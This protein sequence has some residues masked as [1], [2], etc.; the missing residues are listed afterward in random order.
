MGTTGD[1]QPSS[2]GM[3]R[4]ACALTETG[5]STADTK[6][7][8]KTLFAQPEITRRNIVS[9]LLDDERVGTVAS[10]HG[11]ERAALLGVLTS[12]K[13]PVGANLKRA[14]GTMRQ[15]APNFPGGAAFPPNLERTTDAAMEL[16]GLYANPLTTIAMIFKQP[17]PPFEAAAKMIVSDVPLTHYASRVLRV[18][19]YEFETQKP[20][21][22]NAANA[23]ETLS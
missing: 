13:S 11:L 12:E 16:I 15:E 20:A 8:L 17:L 6:S 2:R 7:F 3:S 23:L 5:V 9:A 14:V 10:E 1:I 18:L 19:S 21:L 22:E 4:R